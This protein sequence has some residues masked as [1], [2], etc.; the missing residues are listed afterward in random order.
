M[1]LVIRCGAPRYLGTGVANFAH[2]RGFV[3]NL[4]SNKKIKGVGWLYW[5]IFWVVECDRE[6]SVLSRKRGYKFDGE[7][8]RET[9]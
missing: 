3:G 1:G 4:V 9:G 6:N 7:M 5:D 8:V 2:K